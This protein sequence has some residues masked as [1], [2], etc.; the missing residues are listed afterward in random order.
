MPGCMMKSCCSPWSSKPPCGSSRIG[1]FWVW[2]AA[3]V[4][5]LAMNGIA[6]E[7][8]YHCF[9]ATWFVWM[10][11]VLLIGY[12]LLRRVTQPELPSPEG[13]LP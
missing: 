2:A 4:L 11:P 8:H 1:A 9:H 7:L 5:Y 3:A 12:W 6:Y 13:N 10:P